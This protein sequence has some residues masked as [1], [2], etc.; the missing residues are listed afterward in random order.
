MGKC[1]YKYRQLAASENATEIHPFTL[2]LIQKGELYFPSPFEFND[3]FD[4]VINYSKTITI[5]DIKKLMD[6]LS[7][8]EEQK[9]SLLLHYQNNFLQLPK[10]YASMRQNL[11]KKSDLR[12]FCFSKNPLNILMWS[13][14]AN[15]HTGVCIGFKTYQLDE[16]AFGIRVQEN[17]VNNKLLEANFPNMLIPIPVN[18]TSHVAGEY[19]FGKG[20]A[21]VLI[22]AFLNKAIDWQYEQEYRVVAT[23][24]TLLKNPVMIDVNE[25][26]EIIFGLR[27]SSLLIEQVKDIVFKSPYKR[28]GPKLYQC[29]RIS[30]T[31]ALKKVLLSV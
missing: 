16:R 5:T 23:S 27:A 25:I 9:S 10:I 11:Q 2:S 3:P 4:G 14:Y 31:Y 7:I 12:I 19:D 20:N 28:P 26:E 8:S 30:G 21:E 6:R 22:E 13:H 24:D 17:C 1:F 29:Q 15:S 18:Y